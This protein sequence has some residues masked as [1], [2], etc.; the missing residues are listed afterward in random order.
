MTVYVCV[1]VL[2]FSN[3][4]ATPAFHTCD[5]NHFAGDCCNPFAAVRV[6]H[7]V[8]ILIPSV[9]LAVP[10]YSFSIMFTSS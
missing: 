6:L 7:D 10:H 1:C 8:C 5:F 3:F 4:S 9:N 2:A